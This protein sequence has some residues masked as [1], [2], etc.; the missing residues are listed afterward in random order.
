M[1][2]HKAEFMRLLD[3]FKREE[4]ERGWRDAVSALTQKASE[5]MAPAV[6]PRVLPMPKHV[7]VPGRPGKALALVNDAIKEKPGLNGVE[8]VRLLAEKGTPVVER[9]VRT[10]L[11]RL[12]LAHQ[13]KRRDGRW[14]PV[15]QEQQTAQN[16]SGEALGTPPR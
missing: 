1:T 6:Q 10:C 4:Y 13:V 15:N 8:I 16:A 11:R 2:D 7:K 9:T 14:Y 12:R 3:E 5:M